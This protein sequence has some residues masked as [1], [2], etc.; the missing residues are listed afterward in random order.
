MKFAQ[1]I[2]GYKALLLFTLV[3]WLLYGSTIN[4]DFALDDSMYISQ[5]KMVTSDEYNMLDLFM[6]SHT[7]G[8][9]GVEDQ[10]YRPVTVLAFRILYSLF[11]ESP[12]GYHIINVFLYGFLL[13]GVFNLFLAPVFRLNRWLVLSGTLIYALLPV[14]VE[15]VANCKG[16]EDLLQSALSVW[17]LVF[18]LKRKEGKSL[19]QFITALV[20]LLLGAL[21]K[22]TGFVAPLIGIMLYALSSEGLKQA[23]I[24]KYMGLTLVIALVLFARFLFTGQAESADIDPINNILSSTDFY[25][26]RFIT[27]VYWQFLYLLKLIFPFQ[28]ASDYGIG[29]LEIIQP[30]NPEG[31]L[32]IVFAIST[33]YALWLSFKKDKVLFA[34]LLWYG[35]SMGLTSNL[36]VLIGAGFAERFLFFSSIPAVF[37]IALL[38]E[39]ASPLPMYGLLILALVPVFYLYRTLSR[40]PDWKNNITLFLADVE[41]FPDNAKLNAFYAMEL[42]DKAMIARTQAES[43]SLLM[44]A[45]NYFNKA[46][47]IYPQHTDARYNLGVMYQQTGRMEKA[48]QQYRENLSYFPEHALSNN[49]LGLIF[50]NEG[51]KEKAVKHFRT[52]YA[53]APQNVEIMCNYALSFHVEG[54]LDSARVYYNKVLAI[55]PGHMN[56][57]KNLNTI[58]P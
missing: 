37:A 42:R 11:G 23:D 30:I 56:A 8:Y 3:S 53:F 50:F 21:S 29:T 5:N 46:L 12:K 15:V 36:V 27:A 14:H 4:F 24:K 16:L 49:N 32:A 34:L 10:S 54:Q 39:K 45:E 38:L 26:E 18:L 25:E 47:K 52:A 17:G 43:Q 20:L 44:E 35:L 1:Q 2:T 22:E 33:V 9:S 55:N 7:Y 57:R 31:L 40:V 51:Q 28:L 48:K 19:N 13:H 6:H 41:T 58:S